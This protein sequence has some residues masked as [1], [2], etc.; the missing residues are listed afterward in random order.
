MMHSTY[1]VLNGDAGE[2]H[3]VVHA[4]VSVNQSLRFVH[5][6]V[7]LCV[8]DELVVVGLHVEDALLGG[9]VF[10]DLATEPDGLAGANGLGRNV[11]QYFH[12]LVVVHSGLAVNHIAKAVHCISFAW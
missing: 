2:N 3:G 8:K 12:R 5:V 10:A 1:A 6:E 4:R 7:D 9:R 11:D